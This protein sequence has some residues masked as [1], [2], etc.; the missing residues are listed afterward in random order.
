MDVIY[1]E[2]SFGSEL[3]VVHILR[4]QTDSLHRKGVHGWTSVDD[5]IVL[6]STINLG[7]VFLPFSP[8]CRYHL[9]LQLFCI[10]QVEI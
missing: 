6:L 1:S 10:R 2:I 5:Q 4:A 8:D 3:V 9:I 7:P